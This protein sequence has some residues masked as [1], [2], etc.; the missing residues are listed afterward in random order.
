MRFERHDE[1]GGDTLITEEPGFRSGLPL[2]PPCGA[3]SGGCDVSDFTPVE[4][5]TFLQ[6]AV[7]DLPGFEGSTGNS[8]IKAF[9]R[10]IKST[11]K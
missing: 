3:L 7:K 9:E 11:D 8:L 1:F 6:D 5:I 10:A 2:R 4:G